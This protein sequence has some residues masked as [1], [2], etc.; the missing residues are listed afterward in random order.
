MSPLLSAGASSEAHRAVSRAVNLDCQSPLVIVEEEEEAEEDEAALDALADSADE[1]LR[2]ASSAAAAEATR[3]T[4]SALVDLPGT[5]LARKVQSGL[6]ASRISRAAAA[7]EEGGEGDEL[8]EEEGL[9]LKLTASSP[10]ATSAAALRSSWIS[11][12]VT[13]PRE[14]RAEA[15]SATTED[16]VMTEI[17]VVKEV[18]C[19]ERRRFRALRVGRG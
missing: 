4:F 16:A 8:D 12:S 10:R 14:A 3:E 5:A 19:W 1:L 15:H 9:G 11:S 17:A 13:E 2:L 18:C 6:R 7:A